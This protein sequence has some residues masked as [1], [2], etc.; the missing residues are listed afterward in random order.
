MNPRSASAPSHSSD[1]IRWVAAITAAFGALVCVRLTI[2]N[3]PYFDEIHYL[4][5]ARSLLELSH[6]LNREHPPFGKELIALGMGIW[7]D[8]TLGWRIM[9]AFFGVLTLFASMRAMWF[10]SLSRFAT[11]ATGVL[12]ATG[13]GLFVQSRIAMLD[14]FML[15]FAMVALW[16]CAGAVRDNSSARWR[17]PLAGV[18]LGLSVACKW[19]AAPV[20][21]LPGL[22]FLTVRAR[23][24]GWQLLT[25]RQGAPIQGMSLIEAGVWLGLVPLAAYC[26]AYWPFFF[27]EKG[28]IEP[29]GLIALHA[30]MLELQEQVVKPHTYMSTW[31]EWVL[32]W[33]PI[34]Y[35]YEVSEGAQRGVLMIGNPL[36]MLVGLPAVLWCLWAGLWR[37]SNDALAVALLY[38][39]ALGMWIIA[40]KPVQFYYHYLLPTCFLLAALALAL[41]AA[42]KRGWRVASLAVLAGSV[43]MFAVF[44]P[45]LS[46]APL[47]GA[48]SYEFWMWLHS[49]R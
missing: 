28:A 11:L 6:P 39:A 41:D 10:A 30:T 2:P 17:L 19:N 4:P 3:Q 37:G 15:S 13:F 32:N 49:W 43:A 20:A 33:R 45:I 18:A 26:A 35:Y 1:P 48:N 16:M 14:V 34:W 7:G 31:W 46:A 29:T 47:A 23:G 27:Y 5:A 38:I 9:S 22:T 12:L 21:M 8:G 36:T 42:W 24:A 25:S 44:Y 40:P